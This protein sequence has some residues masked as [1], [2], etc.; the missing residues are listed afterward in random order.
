MKKFYLK[1]KIKNFRLFGN[2]AGF[3]LIEVL[4]SMVILSVGIL[5]LASVV[6]SVNQYQNLAKNMTLATMHT[7]N[8]LEEIKRKGTNEPTGGA[9]G[10]NYL[11]DG[12]VNGYL[13]GYAT[14]NNWTRSSS[15]TING[16]TRKWV[17]TV[18]PATAQATEDFT[19][20]NT[21]NM[22]DVVVTT[23]WVDGKGNTKSV[24]AAT[25]LHKR[26][27]FNGSGS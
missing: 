13:N 25:V 5:G 3:T 23:S 17:L 4:A 11:V 16:F 15:D 7:T 1:A 19:N 18:Y 9:F 12:T 10:F 26:Q 14:P 24:D 27:F 22:V 2:S 6:N 21:I 8:K 20:P